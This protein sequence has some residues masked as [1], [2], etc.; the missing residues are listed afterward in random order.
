MTFR[1]LALSNVKGNFRAYSAFFL[2]SVFS[3]LIFYIYAAFLTHPDVVNGTIAQ[4][5]KVRPGMQYCQYIIIIFSFLFILYSSSA[6]LKT[7]KQEF[8]LFTLFG[9]TR[10][11][12]RKLVIYENLVIGALAIIVGILLG[13]VFSKLFFMALASL[14]DMKDTISFAVPLKALWLT[15]GSFFGLFLVISVWTAVWMRKLEIIDLL[16]AARKPKGRLVYSP[17]LVAIAL[18]CL[19][20]GYIMALEMENNTFIY[21]ALPVLITVIIGTYF[22]FS[23]LSVLLLRVLQK[24]RSIYYNRTNMLI[25]SQLGYK[26]RDN[27][28]ILFVVTLLSAV[29]MTALGTVYMMQIQTKKDM[30]NSSTYSMAYIE[31]GLDSHAIID[32]QELNRIVSEDGFSF[33]REDKVVGLPVYP[34]RVEVEDEGKTRTFTDSTFRGYE[35]SKETRTTSAMVIAESDYN[36]L[37]KE[38]SKK[39]ITVDSGEVVA[40]TNSY[41][42]N[43]YGSGKMSGKINGKEIS[44]DVVKATHENVLNNWTWMISNALTIVMDDRDYKSELAKVPAEQQLVFYGYELN[45]WEKAGATAAKIKALA[46]GEDDPYNKDFSRSIRFS[47]MNETIALTVFIG[48]FISLL[49]FIAAGSMIYFKLFTEISEDQAQFRSLSRIGMTKKEMRRTAVSQIAIIFFIPCIAGMCHALFAMAALDNLM[50]T[51]NWFYSFVVFGIY[52]AMQCIYFLV[53]SNSY[54]KSMLRGA[55][56]PS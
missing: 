4:A 41:E 43:D 26:I 25:L 56:S 48:L 52:V 36:R 38:Q 3:V 31:Q 29:I 27:S 2:S 21:L 19:G 20:S 32:P 40:I 9:M 53:A 34:Y 45:N 22:L 51:S 5:S 44:Y 35:D 42:M 10:A 16:K 33:K 47:E 55:A 11:Q 50:G 18:I 54:M 24:R 6:F 15:A 39:P 23:Q 28:R 46:N 30:L 7:R 8:G 14:L 12:L 13:I 37:A 17:W 49:F 1:S